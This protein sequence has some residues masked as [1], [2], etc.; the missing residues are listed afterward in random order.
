MFRFDWFLAYRP[1]SRE[2]RLRSVLRRLGPSWLA[3]PV[4]RIV[5]ACFL[6]LFALLTFY[7]V[8]PY[9]AEP[10]WQ[11]A[12]WTPVAVDAVGKTVVVQGDGA[13]EPPRVGHRVLLSLVESGRT[14]VF[15]EF[16]VAAAE[17]DQLTLR[18]VD[19]AAA[20]QLD[21]L[22]EVFQPCTLSA[23][24]PTAWPSHYADDLLRKER[25]PAE[26]VLSL[27][28]LVGGSTALASRRMNAALYFAAAVLLMCA[29]FP[30]MFC[31]YVCPLGTLIDCFDGAVA[32]LGSLV[33]RLVGRRQESRRKVSA[34]AVGR[35]G[36]WRFGLL[37]FVL[38]AAATGTTVAGYL[39]AI[40]LVTRGAV[41]LLRPPMTAAARDWHQAPPWKLPH[42]A[43]ALSLLGVI[44]LG[45][46]GRRFWCRTLCPTGALC[47]LPSLASVTER[48]VDQRCV[49]CG[50][51]R[52]ICAF[53]AIEP[54]YS[55]RTANCTFCQDCG[56]ACPAGAIHFVPR[57]SK[58]SDDEPSAIAK[59]AATE[60]AAA[61]KA[62][63]ASDNRA[64]ATASAA[65][66]AAE[67]SARRPTDAAEARPAVAPD[68]CATDRS[69]KVD[70]R[71][72]WLATVA[73]GAAGGL[74]GWAIAWGRGR[75]EAIVRPP[76]SL[77]E[78]LFLQTCVRCLHCI[79]ACPN[80]A[81]WPAG[82]EFGL[83]AFWTPRLAAEWAGCEPSCAN[84]GQVCPTGAIRPLP[85]DEKRFARLG[86]AVVDQ[87]ACLPYAGRA[88]C[89]HCVDQCERAGYRAIEFVRVGTEFDEQGRPIEDTGFLAPVVLADRCVGCGQ[90]EN[91]CFSV[92]VVREALLERSAI[93]V[94]AGGGNDDRIET[95][96]YS[97]L[98]RHGR[99]DETAPSGPADTY[100]PDFL[101]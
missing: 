67:V 8:W 25:V 98:R 96:S 29:I 75:S 40:P 22:A 31:G 17:A 44:G 4:R 82:L 14:R 20:A 52:E 94:E 80:D 32:R 3:S 45:V 35:G 65:S 77:P 54:D 97:E 19:S 57:W 38:V 15:G 27:D 101:K 59:A 73:C 90:C 81:L 10:L 95:G 78:T 6:F 34:A 88:D 28:P 23:G 86:L 16:T 43:A 76:G 11:S 56:G 50:K 91:R 72:G 2:G 48:R 41:A 47:S 49:K 51:C 53:D 74:C 93:R 21:A 36:R 62:A 12:G 71:R 99:G 5:Q 66:A 69:A 100:L 55:T 33:G 58:E 84:C 79:Q 60:K 83:D 64:A 37:A 1:A 61:E 18:P 24:D 92:N 13:A 87:A 7:V 39:A 70:S 9:T 89:R 46:F 68:H 26:T 85:I 30:R 63:A 42:A